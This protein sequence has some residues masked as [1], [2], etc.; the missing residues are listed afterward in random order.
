MPDIEDLCNDLAA[1]H[2]S[3]DAIVANLDE[4]GWSTPTPAAGWDVR[5]T[6]SHLIFFDEQATLAID[7]PPAFEEH[8]SGLIASASAG[9]EPDVAIGRGIEGAAVLE[10]WRNSRSALIRRALRA[11]EDAGG[12]PPRIAWYGPPMSLA[13]FISAR[14]METWAHGA[15]IRDALGEPLE[16]SATVRL[17]HICHL[18]YGARTFAF[19][20]H[21]VED[22]GDPVAMVVEAPGGGTWTWGPPADEVANVI[23]GSALDIALVFTQ[24]RH[25]S[26]TGVKVTGPTAARWVSIAQAFAGPPTVTPE[27]R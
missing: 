5:D 20:V 8:K 16:S 21:G 15:D 26:R 6:V 25:P 22:P 19:A 18:A 27:G 9:E 1:E 2:A 14:I 3:L 11:S 23:T 17:K 24:R 12:A 4:A 7:D 10:R 13:S